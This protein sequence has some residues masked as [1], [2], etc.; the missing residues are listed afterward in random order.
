MVLLHSVGEGHL[1]VVSVLLLRNKKLLS[2]LRRNQQRNLLKKIR[3]LMLMS[4]YQLIARSPLLLVNLQEMLPSRPLPKLCQVLMIL[5][6][7]VILVKARPLLMVFIAVNKLAKV[8]DMAQVKALVKV[9][10]LE[11]VKEPDSVLAMALVK[12]LAITLDKVPV[13]ELDMVLVKAQVTASA[14]A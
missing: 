2:H 12:E 8:L 14:T 5:K 10:D 1:L 4:M 6:H 7:L 13:K 3:R 11:L 9:L